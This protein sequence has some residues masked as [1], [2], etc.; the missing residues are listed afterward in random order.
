MA[1]IERQIFENLYNFQMNRFA[2]LGYKTYISKIIDIESESEFH[3][4]L[5]SSPSIYTIMELI[6]LPSE[7]RYITSY[8][9]ERPRKCGSGTVSHY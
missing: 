7:S 8:Y 6:S 1:E 2:S 9:I 4:L 5:K 3:R